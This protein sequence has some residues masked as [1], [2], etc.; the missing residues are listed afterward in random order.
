MPPH[1]IHLLA[2]SGQLFSNMA[3]ESLSCC[4]HDQERGICVPIPGPPEKFHGEKIT[5]ANHFAFFPRKII[6]TRGAEKN[7]KI[8]SSWYQY[9][10]LISQMKTFSIRAAMKL[11]QSVATAADQHPWNSKGGNRKALAHHNPMIIA[12][13]LAWLPL[14]RLAVKNNFF[15]CKFWAVKNF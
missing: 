6:W 2:S 7:L 13:S 3:L 15:L 4:H 14:Q 1:T 12:Q 8:L 9:E 10:D 5:G 11:E